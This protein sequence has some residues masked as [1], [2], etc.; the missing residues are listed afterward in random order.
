MITTS[1][2]H[3][4]SKTDEGWRDEQTGLVWLPVEPGTHTHNKALKL[5][6]DTKRLPTLGELR[7][8]WEHDACEVIEDFEDYWYWS[9]SVHPDY[10]NLAYVLDGHYGNVYDDYRYNTF[11][12]VRCVRSR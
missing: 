10:S 1:K 12:A 4:W 2:G 11:N 6:N 8:A 5:Q 3:K 9:S 7:I